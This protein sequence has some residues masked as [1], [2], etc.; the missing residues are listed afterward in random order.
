MKPKVAS[1]SK[2]PKFDNGGEFKGQ[3]LPN[4]TVSMKRPVKMVPVYDYN[5]AY[6]DSTGRQIP[7]TSSEFHKQIQL[8]PKFGTGFEAGEPILESKKMVPADKLPSY[9]DGTDTTKGGINLL[10]PSAVSAYGG[11]ATG[12]GGLLKN[13][14]ATSAGSY[15][16]NILGDAGKYASMGAALGPWGAAGGAVVGG[17]M[18]L[19]DS[20][21]AAAAQR[22]AE[23]KAKINSII[24]TNNNISNQIQAQNDLSTQVNPRVPG[25]NKGASSF[26]GTLPGLIGL[27]KRENYNKGVV[28]TPRPNA[29]VAKEEGIR[30][31]LTGQISTVPGQYSPSNPDT[32]PAVLT[33]GSSVYSKNKEQVLPGGKSTPADI[34]AK[35]EK[36]QN[37]SNEILNPKQGDDRRS[38]LDILTAKLNQRNIQK[39]SENLNQFNSLINPQPQVPTPN[40]IPQPQA[41]IPGQQLPNMSYGAN[42]KLPRY[43][44]GDPKI[45]TWDH[46]GIATQEEMDAHPNVIWKN[47]Y[48]MSIKTPGQYTPTVKA[49]QPITNPQ[50]TLNNPAVQTP[51]ST[52]V[53]P[54]VTPAQ[55]QQPTQQ[56]SINPASK[57]VSETRNNAMSG[58]TYGA[59]TGNIVTPSGQTISKIQPAVGVPSISNPTNP[60]SYVNTNSDLYPKFN[61]TSS[62]ANYDMYPQYNSTPSYS[63]SAGQSTS[64]VNSANPSSPTV[65]NL[66]SGI[67]GKLSGI[68]NSLMS[69][70]PLAYNAHNSAPEVASPVY[71]DFINPNQR[72]NIAPQLAESTRQRQISRFNNASLNTNTGA[73][74]A[75]GRDAY[76]GG[77]EQ[78]SNIM[79]T[80][81]NANNQYKDQYANRYNQNAEQNANENRR[82]YD[83]NSRNR[84]ASRNLQS[85]NAQMLSQYGQ[86][87]QLMANQ[88]R[89]DLLNSN[90]WGTYANQS[91]DPK[92]LATITNMLNSYS[93]SQW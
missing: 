58:Q 30:D 7:I 62:G 56:Q 1:K 71:S 53:T 4:V 92:R 18:G 42:K 77:V 33:P 27:T 19:L 68:G 47:G 34:V 93:N 24:S 44:M 65:N 80:A 14:D 75:Y 41:I 64:S 83:L 76:T 28:S 15:A 81:E 43:D 72:Y 61:S 11:I 13:S 6:I 57:V 54:Q 36:V 37:H 17:V 67:G 16:G 29:M 85:A 26:S 25:L 21:R 91:L 35:L 31:G 86:T 22:S 46:P 79:N 10:D 32:V 88:K 8:N 49:T 59:G 66:A 60:M 69:L 87:R 70:A 78:T 2:L 45:D 9:D 5:G 40:Q 23:R 55:S 63:Q 89:A 20:D 84:A 90:I 48:A 38:K 12:I 73:D 82:I 3:D 74:M 39:Q 52:P 51:I 50:Q